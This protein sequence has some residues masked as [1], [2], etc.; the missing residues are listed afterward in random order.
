MQN[1][2]HID[3][4]IQSKDTT[5]FDASL[6][7]QSPE[8][9]TPKFNIN[10]EF[11]MAKLWHQKGKI[12]RAIAGYRKVLA[13]NPM[14]WSSLLALDELL[15]TKGDNQTAIALYRQAIKNLAL[16]EWTQQST[17]YQRNGQIEK[18]IEEWRKVLEVNPTHSEVLQLLE[19]ALTKQGDLTSAIAAYRSAI[20]RDPNNAEFHKRHINLI[21]V[22][23]GID[24]A[25]AYY[26]LTRADKK[27]IEISPTA[28]LCCVVVRNELPRLPY[29]LNYY[30]QKGVDRF[31]IVDN[32][33][34]DATLEYLLQQ[35]D[36][37]VWSSAKSFNQVN[38]GSV[39]FDLLLRK[40]G[41][42]RWCLTV[43]ADELLYY[44]NCEHETIHQL[45]Q[46]LDKG[47]YRAYTAMLLDMYSDQTVQNTHYKSGEDF[48][49]VCPYFDRQYYHRKYPQASPYRNQT[50]YFGGVRERVFGR[51]G[52]YLL[53][54]VPL[55]KYGLETV[56]IGGQHLT[57]LPESKIAKESGCLLH[58][59]YFSLFTK[60][61]AQEVKRQEHYG[62][63]HQ[64]AEYF[65]TLSA[66]SALTLYDEKQ[67]LRLASSQ[68]LV[69]LGIIKVESES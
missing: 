49:E 37:Y 16:I 59:K 55:L 57:N 23:A 27:A 39:W 56:M 66:N 68:Q 36:V 33:S 62:G 40:Y 15:T 18:A 7:T 25:F 48:L 43:D 65:R 42:D 63:G 5:S 4:I 24:A 9:T 32:Q 46:R 61:V 50:L 52:E 13:V 12:E 31:L 21:V 64:Y 11:Q 1:Q 29:F 20:E 34:T 45:C 47:Q 54:K 3:S 22:E 14:H 41:I 6:E 30:R 35:N 2:L 69:Q 51:T 26:E 58:F 19:S 53:S 67:S 28:L 8:N 10:V 60:Y 38:F 44:P 17:I